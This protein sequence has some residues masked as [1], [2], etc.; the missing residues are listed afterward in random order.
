LSKISAETRNQVYDSI[1]GDAG[2][3]SMFRSSSGLL[4]RDDLHHVFDDL[5][6]SLYVKDNTIHVHFFSTFL[7]GAG[8]LHGK[9][10]PQSCFAEILASD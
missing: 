10:I 9:A 5:Y 6:L 1:Y 3:L 7:P 2:G 4:L 8:E